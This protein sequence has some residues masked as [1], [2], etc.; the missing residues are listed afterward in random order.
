MRT[1]WLKLPCQGHPTGKSTGRFLWSLVAG[2]F[3]L[4]LWELCVSLTSLDHDFPL[5]ISMLCFVLILI[6]SLVLQ[7][8]LRMLAGP[9]FLVTPGEC[10]VSSWFPAAFTG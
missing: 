2:L 5:P 4:L 8:S 10:Q 9:I 3:L 1:T 7:L 6:I